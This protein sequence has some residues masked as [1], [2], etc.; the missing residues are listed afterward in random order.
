MEDHSFGVRKMTV[1]VIHILRSSQ[2]I[3]WYPLKRVTWLY[4]NKWAGV[5]SSVRSGTHRRFVPERFSLYNRNHPVSLENQAILLLN[6]EIWLAQEWAWQLF[7]S[8]SALLILTKTYNLTYM[9]MG[10]PEIRWGITRFDKVQLVWRHI[11]QRFRWKS[12]IINSIIW[13]VSV[14]GLRWSQELVDCLSWW[15]R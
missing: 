8:I 7:F 9:K 13:V 4:G 15:I 1:N 11:H 3:S 2:D 5:A 14:Y 12:V 10:G 6:S